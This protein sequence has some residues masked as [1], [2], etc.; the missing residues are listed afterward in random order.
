MMIFYLKEQLKIEEHSPRGWGLSEE[1]GGSKQ[2]DEGNCMR[3]FIIC[4]KKNKKKKE[5]L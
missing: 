5:E 2:L 3:S 1:R 4:I